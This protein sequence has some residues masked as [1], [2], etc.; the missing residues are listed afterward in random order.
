MTQVLD[1]FKLHGG[2]DASSAFLDIGSGLGRPALHAIVHSNVKE[3]YGIECDPVKLQK[4]TPFVT[5]VI[6]EL[7][8]VFG[9]SIFSSTCLP[10]LICSPIEKLQSLEGAT[11]IYSA[12]EGFSVAAMEAVGKLFAASQT[13]QAICIVQR[14]F[15]ALEPEEAMFHLG[16]GS[17]KLVLQAP[18]FMSGSRRQLVAYVFVRDKKP[19]KSLKAKHSG[20]SSMVFFKPDDVISTLKRDKAESLDSGAKGGKRSRGLGEA[21]HS[22][23]LRDRSERKPRQLQDFDC[24]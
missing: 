21:K 3:C 16:F 7:S 6:H 1:A 23:G 11:H 13:A 5:S 22:H 15:R 20:L 10:K 14:S 12:W 4:A 8:P 9:S 18:V 17:L 19:A 2:L 24:S